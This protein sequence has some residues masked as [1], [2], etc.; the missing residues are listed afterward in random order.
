MQY[1]KLTALYEETLQEMFLARVEAKAVQAE[2]EAFQSLRRYHVNSLV[3]QG[4]AIA[5]ENLSSTSLFIIITDS[6]N[7]SNGLETGIEILNN[8]AGSPNATV[9]GFHMDEGVTEFTSM[10]GIGFPVRKKPSWDHLPGLA[11]VGTVTPL[12]LVYDVASGFLIGIHHPIPDDALK[13]RLFY[14]RWAYRGLY[15]EV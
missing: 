12:V 7:C 9:Q 2:E 13:S 1:K 6:F 3:P 10:Y 11:S 4:D 8:I 15:N 14:K 5:T